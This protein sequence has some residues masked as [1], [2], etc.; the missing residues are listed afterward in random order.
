MIPTQEGRHPE[1]VFLLG[2]APHFNRTDGAEVRT[3]R[4]ARAYDVYVHVTGLDALAAQWRRRG[5]D[6]LNGP[7]D[8]SYQQRE[9]VRGCN[10]LVVAFDEDTEGGA[11]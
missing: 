10:G 6:I 4:A 5:A 9:L 3:G 11:P 7:V 8:R 1:V 2:R